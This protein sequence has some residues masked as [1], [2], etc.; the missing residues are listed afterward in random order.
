MPAAV[1]EFTRTVWESGAT[2]LRDCRY[3]RM[4]FLRQDQYVGRSLALYGEYNEAEGAL[5]AQVIQRG[6]TVLDVGANF[7]AHTLQFARLVGPHGS[8][9]AIEP[10]RVLFQML[11]ANMALNEQFHVQTLHA[12]AGA[13]PGSILV[14]D[15]DYTQP[16][17]FGGVE[18]GNTV[19]GE[20]VAV[21]TLDTLQLDALRL[22]K[23]DVE[24][25]EADVLRGAVKQIELHRPILH[26]ENDRRER[27]AELIGLIEGLGYQAYWH[28]SPLFNPQN[29][30]RQAA[31]LFGAIVSINLFC[32]PSEQDAHVAALRRVAGPHD[33][34]ERRG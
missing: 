2:L 3:G 21:A 10:Q 24:G 6:D 23:I 7:G 27:S 8:V 17:N 15:L 32:V 9:V 16:E 20:T 28:I 18:V 22:I 33:W 12:A 13:A 34:W 1:S 26:I 14:P 30:N 25:M 31:D 29:Y 11:C 5:F 19:A 4:L